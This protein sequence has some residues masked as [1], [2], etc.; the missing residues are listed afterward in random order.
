MYEY[1]TT[2]SEVAE[3]CHQASGREAI[4]VDTEFVRTRTLYPQ[5]GLI[6]I[7]DGQRLVL[8]DPVQGSDL[9]PLATLLTDQ[10]VVKILHSCSEDLETFQTALGVMPEPVFDSQFAASICEIGTMLGYAKLVEMR[11]D[12]VLDKGESRTDWLARPLTEQQLDYAANDVLYLFQ[13]YPALK[14][15]V[16]AR[17]RLDWVYD[18]I[19]QL[20]AKKKA[21]LP[22]DFA[23][24]TIKNAWQLNRRQLNILKYLAKWRLEFARQKNMALNFVVKEVN[25]LSIAK[26]QP[27][28]KGDLY[29]ISGLSPQEIRRYHQ[30]II[31]A[32]Q[33][34]TKVDEALY[35]EKVERLTDFADYKSLSNLIRQRCADTAERVGIP[36]EVLGSKKQINQLLQWLWYQQDETRLKGLMPDLVT[37]WRG[38]LLKAELEPLLSAKMA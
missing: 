14:Q 7:Y 2:N 13:L 25:L 8:I 10:N 6:Q 12:V 23:Y 18:E 5:I 4:A 29:T 31:E 27:Q 36:V 34:A 33:Q 11:L 16:A 32:V 24:V 17:G 19:R 30:N 20:A 35:P 26:R 21:D 22:A 3:F 28:S 9:S 1:L 37:G 38:E 15:E